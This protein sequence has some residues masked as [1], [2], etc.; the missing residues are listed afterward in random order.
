MAKALRKKDV[1]RKRPLFDT[2]LP[3]RK[4]NFQILGLGIVVILLGYGAMLEGSVEGVMP[5][6]VSPILLLLG[7][8]VIIPIGIMY[9]PKARGAEDASKSVTAQ[10]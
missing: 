7:Y 4:E 2:A 6:V 5:L 9:K 10:P 3:L 1:Q 8:C